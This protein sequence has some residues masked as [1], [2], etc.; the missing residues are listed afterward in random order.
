M[1]PWGSA[2]TLLPCFVRVLSGFGWAAALGIAGRAARAQIIL[3]GVLK[4]GERVL[5][6]RTDTLIVYVWL[7]VPRL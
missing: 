6:L 7:D 5:R 3:F 4:L 1:V 2:A